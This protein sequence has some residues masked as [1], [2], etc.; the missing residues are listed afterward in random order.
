[1]TADVEATQPAESAQPEASEAPA[2]APAEATPVGKQKPSLP[3]GVVSPITALNALKQ[4]KLVAADYKPQQMYGFVKNPGKVDP[5]PVKHY[6]A[7]GQVHDAAQLNE[8]G[9]T[10]TRPG[11]I[12][13][14]VVAWWSRKG[15][16]DKAKAAEKKAKAEAKA[17]KEAEKAQA[18]AAAEAAGTA[19]PTDAAQETG[20][21][22][23]ELVDSGEF[24]EA[25]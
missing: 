18:A 10:V 21:D 8:H 12:V 5:F 19:T 9:I 23:G 25:Q 24:E 15:E 22:E 7:P 20:T 3:E 16:R 17:A 1:M 13:E 11:V 2:E 4:K 6:D 14:E